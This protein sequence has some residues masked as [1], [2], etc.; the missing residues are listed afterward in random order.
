MKNTK[1]KL[2]EE[3][4]ALEAELKEKKV[5][6]SKSSLEAVGVR[7]EVSVVNTGKMRTANKS[8]FLSDVKEVLNESHSSLLGHTSQEGE[9]SCRELDG[10]VMKE[11]DDFINE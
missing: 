10:D 1:R 9:D 2:R 3:R 4:A 8:Q 7:S 6:S 11:L 5:K